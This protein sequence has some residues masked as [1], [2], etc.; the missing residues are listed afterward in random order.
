MEQIVNLHIEKLPEAV[1]LATSD[2]I[3]IRK[4]APC[5]TPEPPTGP[6]NERHHSNLS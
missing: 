6:S 4:S 2:E 5:Q 1:Y 3:V